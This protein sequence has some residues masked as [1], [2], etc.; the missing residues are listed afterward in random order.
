MKQLNNDD[1]IHLCI[2]MNWFERGSAKQ[3]N[4][5]FELNKKGASVHELAIVIW[6]CSKESSKNTLDL[7]ESGIKD[8]ILNKK[9]NRGG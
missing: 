3:Y 9:Q 5:L 2:E 1:L 6:L 8:A 4:R 7:I